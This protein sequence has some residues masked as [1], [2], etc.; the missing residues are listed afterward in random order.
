VPPFRDTLERPGR[1]PTVTTRNPRAEARDASPQR[2][3]LG[4]ELTS[5]IDL[6][7]PFA[8]RCLHFQTK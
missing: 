7:H 3:N 1:F 6:I 8:G 5:H 2:G 4:P